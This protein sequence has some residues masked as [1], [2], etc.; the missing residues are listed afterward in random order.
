MT[1]KEENLNEEK[2]SLSFVEQMIEQDLAEGKNGGR[3]QTRFPP[4][5]NGYLHIGHAKAIAMDFGAAERHGGIC[6]LRF[7]D[8]NPT[9][10]ILNT[11]RVLNT[12]S[13]GSVTN[14]RMFTMPATISKSYGT[15]PF[16]SSNKVVHTWTNR[17]LNRLHNRKV[18][19]PVLAR[20]VLSATDPLKRT[21]ACLSL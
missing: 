15:L 19:L 6:N 16:G 4:E 14:G 7:D 11:L 1:T 17:V 21:S 9:R 20:T 10:R 3:I 8:T 5:P 2:K 12:I 13:N 18:L